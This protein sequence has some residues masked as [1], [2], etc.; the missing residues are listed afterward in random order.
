MQDHATD[1][2]ASYWADYLYAHHKRS[3]RV[4]HYVG[5]I[6]GLCASAYGLVTLQGIAVLAGV[7]GAYGMAI[8][9]HYV[10]EGRKPLVVR[11]PAWGAASDFR[12]LALALRGRLRAEF[13]KNAVE[14]Q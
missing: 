7:V 5:T 13:E 14:M 1:K 8:G 2:F 9:S 12:M 11:N 6:Y 3:T 4:C 10:F